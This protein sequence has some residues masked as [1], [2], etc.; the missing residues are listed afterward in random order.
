MSF[1][2]STFVTGSAVA[3]GGT[4]AF[5][6]PVGTSIGHFNLNEGPHKLY[7]E[8]HNS[9]YN[10]LDDFTISFS[11]AN[12]T[13]TYNGSTS[14]PASTKVLLM[15]DCGGRN[16][17]RQFQD[18]LEI[19]GFPGTANVA[20]TGVNPNGSANTVPLAGKLP[21]MTVRYGS[22]TTISTTKFLAT[23][24][25]A[26]TT[27]Q[28]LATAVINDVPRACQIVSS[29]AGDT[30]QV[31]TI[32]GFDDLGAALTES[33]TANGTTPVF[34]KK[35]FKQVNSYQSSASMA[36]NLSIGDS[37][38]LGIPFFLPGAGYVLK[39]IQDGASATAGTFVAG[40]SVKQTA[41]TGDS[42]G[43][44]TPNATLNGTIALELLIASSDETWRGGTNFAG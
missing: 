17:Q 37:K 6:Y 9:L 39:E 15:L 10:F 31:I 40:V 23:T 24:A 34:G 38:I 21:V 22:P 18:S 28:T 8:G 36:G 43:T 29:N 12:A 42:K 16:D 2:I 13:V 25:V 27:L 14:I 35:A 4:M 32:R 30:T 3:S 1:R 5:T 41:T 19:T 7:V 11:A 20:N 44:W 33:I 26:G